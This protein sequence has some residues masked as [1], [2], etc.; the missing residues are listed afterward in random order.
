MWENIMVENDK[1]V[2]ISEYSQYVTL[3]E[4]RIKSLAKE[5]IKLQE[6]LE[7]EKTDRENNKRLT[8]LWAKNKNKTFRVTYLLGKITF[9]FIKYETLSN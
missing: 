3:L 7:T 5:N 2:K 9:F 4:T 8:E 6:Q 1:N